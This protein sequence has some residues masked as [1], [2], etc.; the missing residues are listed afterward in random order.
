MQPGRYSLLVT[1]RFTARQAAAMKSLGCHGFASNRAGRLLNRERIS[2]HAGPPKK[3]SMPSATMTIALNSMIASF[4]NR[5]LA[6]VRVA[7]NIER[8]I[9]G[10]RVRSN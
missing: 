7:E 3:K 4:N 5:P 9:A 8:Y 1:R 6:K 10:F 2:G